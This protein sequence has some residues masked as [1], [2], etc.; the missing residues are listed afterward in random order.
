MLRLMAKLKGN[1]AMMVV[2]L[3]VKGSNLSYESGKSDTKRVPHF[4][5]TK[6]EL[7]KGRGEVFLAWLGVCYIRSKTTESVVNASSWAEP[8]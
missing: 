4:Q 2:N 6:M 8:T 1:Q 7:L 3:L 5:R